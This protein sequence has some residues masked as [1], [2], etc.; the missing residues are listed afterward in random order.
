M[1]LHWKAI[2]TALLTAITVAC[3]TED[4]GR[5]RTELSDI[6]VGISQINAS[7]QLLVNGY[8]LEILPAS[9][10]DG[11]KLYNTGA[12]AATSIKLAVALKPGCDYSATIK[13]GTIGLGQ[14]LPLAATYYQTTDAFQLSK[15]VID[16]HIKTPKDQRKRLQVALVVALTDDGKKQN[17]PDDPTK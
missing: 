15:D 17:L 12:L 9:G 8:T 7:Y 6:D 13:L 10:C 5:P 3:G 16:Q 14:F 11:T 4:Q 2:A 1:N